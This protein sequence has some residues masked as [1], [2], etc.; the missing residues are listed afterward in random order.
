MNRRQL[1]LWLPLL[2]HGA[3][4]RGHAFSAAAVLSLQLLLVAEQVW[5]ASVASKWCCLLALLRCSH[6]VRCWSRSRPRGLAL[7]QKVQGL[8]AVGVLAG[9]VLPACS[10]VC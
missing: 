8:R 2:L 10:S 6:C 4:L 5:C 7:L 1:L 9:C 3:D